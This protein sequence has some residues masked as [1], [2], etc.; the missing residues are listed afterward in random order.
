DIKDIKLICYLI[1]DFEEIFECFN[2][3]EKFDIKINS[4]DYVDSL[5]DKIYEV[6]K[7]K[8]NIFFDIKADDLML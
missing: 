8:N 4:S 3:A 1:R 2:L 6:I 5:K 7:Q